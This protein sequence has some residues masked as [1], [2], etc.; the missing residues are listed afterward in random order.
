M[1]SFSF[2]LD[3]ACFRLDGATGRRP[4]ESIEG[5]VLGPSGARPLL[6]LSLVRD[7]VAVGA[8]RVASAT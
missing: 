8:L 4:R 5:E 1:P 3:L 7:D 6:P 2:G